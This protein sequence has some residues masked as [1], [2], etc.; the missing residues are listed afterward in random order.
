MDIFL[1]KIQYH[2][3]QEWRYRHA[4]GYPKLARAAA[5]RRDYELDLLL[6]AGRKPARPNLAARWLGARLVALGERL[7]AA[8][9]A[10]AS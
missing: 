6:R 9:S 3:E 5:L 7:R 4:V 10:P 1:P 2:A 8:P